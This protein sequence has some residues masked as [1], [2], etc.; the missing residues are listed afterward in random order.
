MR[1]LCRPNPSGVSI[2]RIRAGAIVRLCHRYDV[3][4]LEDGAYKEL[5]HDHR[6]VSLREIECELLRE[7]HESYD[8]KGR[9]M[10]IGTLSK[11]MAPGVRIGWIEAPPRVVEGVVCLKQVTDLHTTNFTQMIAAEFLRSHAAAFLPTLRSE[12]RTRCY[13]ARDAVDRH[14]GGWITS[15]IQP[16]GG[17]YLWVELASEIDMQA[18]LHHAV[19][20]YGVAYVP[21]APFFAMSPRHN[22][23]R[24]CYSY[25]LGAREFMTPQT[26]V[27]VVDGLR[28]EKSST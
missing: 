8:D 12:N 5:Y 19:E 2:S 10:F 9:V 25:L 28:S 1:G 20:R 3:P 24:L 6:R 23:M 4:I 18:L 7:A 21:G 27:V 17:F 13:A 11:V 14:L 22:T 26:F 16:S 15:C